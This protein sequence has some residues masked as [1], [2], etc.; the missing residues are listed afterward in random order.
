LFW[1]T[2]SMDDSL[3]VVPGTLFSIIH[4]GAIGLEL[5]CAGVD[6]CTKFIL[7]ILSYIHVL[8]LFCF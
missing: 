3:R 8:C 4:H 1:F 6:M 5:A 2:L 7:M